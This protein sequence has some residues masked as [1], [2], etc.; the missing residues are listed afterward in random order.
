[1][2]ASP[3]ASNPV[4]PEFKPSGVSPA[5]ARLALDQGRIEQ[6][7]KSAEDARLGAPTSRAM[8]ALWLALEQDIA[9]RLV[10]LA[11]KAQEQGDHGAGARWLGLLLRL[12]PSV[13]ERAERSYA[14][15][16]S[17]QAGP[18]GSA[19][20]GPGAGPNAEDAPRAESRRRVV[21]RA[22]SPGLA[23][24]AAAPDSARA[25]TDSGA[26]LSSGVAGVIPAPPNGALRGEDPG[27]SSTVGAHGAAGVPPQVTGRFLADDIGEVL[28]VD[29]GE[30][31]LS[32]GPDPRALPLELPAAP[33]GACLRLTRGTADNGAAPFQAWQRSSPRRPWGAQIVQSGTV[34]EFGPT[35]RPWV[36]LLPRFAEAGQGTAALLLAFERGIQAGQAA[37]LLWLGGAVYLGRTERCLLRAGTLADEHRLEYLDGQL[38]IT[39]PGPLI[40][41]NSAAAALMSRHTAPVGPLLRLPLPVR[42]RLDFEL[43]SRRPA[44]WMRFEPWED[45]R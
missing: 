28:L 22:Q 40:A 12:D 32:A 9:E 26:D 24:L 4:P 33:P 3:D 21:G 30:L 37:S 39:G 8:K 44:F 5:G 7:L 36:R 43:G 18:P 35:G 42:E 17:V 29:A 25:G 11:K 10:G 41:R 31:W 19:D 1:M 27:L 38:E 2:S 34:M 16:L 20:G 15:R 14:R 6:A 13:A 23:R 45:Q